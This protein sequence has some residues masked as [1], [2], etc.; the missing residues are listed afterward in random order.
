MRGLG[1]KAVQRTGRFLVQ[2]GVGLEK[3]CRVQASVGAGLGLR[4]GSG[5]G[6][7]GWGSRFLCW[8][9]VRVRVGQ[10]RVVCELICEVQMRPRTGRSRSGLGSMICGVQMRVETGRSRSGLGRHQGQPGPPEGSLLA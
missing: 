7:S 5:P 9:D 4:V 6:R 10:G 1:K 8:D 2:A 3:V